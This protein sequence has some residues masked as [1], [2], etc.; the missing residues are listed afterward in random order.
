MGKFDRKSLLL[1][2]VSCAVAVFGVWLGSLV[3]GVWALALVALGVVLVVVAALRGHIHRL[4]GQTLMVDGIL[5]VGMLACLSLE[6]SGLIVNMV[7][8]ALAVFL[9]GDAAAWFRQWRGG[10]R[11][12]ASD[13]A[14][15]GGVLALVVQLVLAVAMLLCVGGVVFA[16]GG[17]AWKWPLAVVLLLFCVFLL[18]V[19]VRSRSVEVGLRHEFRVG[20]ELDVVFIALALYAC[21]MGN[22]PSGLWLPLWV[23]VLDVLFFASDIARWWLDRPARI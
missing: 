11:S 12:A 16:S 3:G 13:G 23:V 10:S 7:F 20:L 1:L 9:C 22:L 2:A 4:Y 21:F 6:Q 14:G 19:I 15:R 5:L 8:A 17:G 18:A